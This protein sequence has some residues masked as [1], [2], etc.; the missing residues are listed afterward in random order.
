M[1]KEVVSELVDVV[2]MDLDRNET[3]GKAAPNPVVREFE[4]LMGLAAQ[5][6][7]K[8]ANLVDSEFRIPKKLSKSVSKLVSKGMAVIQNSRCSGANRSSSK[9]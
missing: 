8:W 2:T 4:T 1:V 9:R 6:E 5:L 7:E 3:G